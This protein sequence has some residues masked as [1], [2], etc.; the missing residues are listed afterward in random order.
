MTSWMANWEKLYD[1]LGIKEFIY[2]ISSPSIQDMLFPIRIICLL[3][4]AFFLC[5]IIWFYVNSSYLKFQFLQDTTE[6]FSWHAYGLQEVNRM[7]KKII[8]KTESGSE[9]EYK[10]AI[11]EADDF[12]QNVLIIK[13]Q[14]KFAKYFI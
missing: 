10:L 7:W 8:K 6:F 9:N 1:L 13:K 14:T 5:A 3:F 4:A 11:I 2:F 12:L